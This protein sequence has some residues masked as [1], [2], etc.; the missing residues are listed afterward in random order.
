MQPYVD[1]YLVIACKLKFLALLL[2]TD[3]KG[4]VSILLF[5][6]TWFGVWRQQLSSIFEMAEED[7]W[8]TLDC[9]CS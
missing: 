7:Y 9:V 3:V 5:S 1:I 4:L 6:F 2:N 8:A